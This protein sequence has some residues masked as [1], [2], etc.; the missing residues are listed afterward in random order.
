MKDKKDFEAVFSHLADD[1]TFKYNIT[2]NGAMI[3]GKMFGLGWRAGY[4]AGV[5]MGTYAVVLDT[6]DRKQKWKGLKNREKDI[7][8]IYGERFC[9]LAPTLFENTAKY[10]EE[11]SLP[12]I[13]V[14]YDERLP[15]DTGNY[16]FASNLTYTISMFI[17]GTPSRILIKIGDRELPQRGTSRLRR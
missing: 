16:L 12:Y 13:G 5:S 3:D 9:S 14:R 4:D 10:L 6:E 17:S 11:N 15:Q 1:S 2:R 7:H 8:N